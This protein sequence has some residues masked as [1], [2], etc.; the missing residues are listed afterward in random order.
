[1]SKKKKI[2]PITNVPKRGVL[3]TLV[4]LFL[5][6]S[7]LINMYIAPSIVAASLGLLYQVSLIIA[8]MI[9]AFA[10]FGIWYMRKWGAFIYIVLT[11][12]NQPLLLFMDKWYPGAAILPGIIIVVLI[13]KFRDMK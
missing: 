8:T 9:T 11:I 6:I 2:K 1:M 5:G 3:I 13:F 7:C 10:T 12:V 4:C